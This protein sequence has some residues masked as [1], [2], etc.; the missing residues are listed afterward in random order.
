M[1]KKTI[2]ASVKMTDDTKAGAAGV[3]SSAEKVSAALTKM[4]R[5]V[6]KA[7]MLSIKERQSAERTL[8]EQKMTSLRREGEMG[9]QRAALDA[10]QLE[11]TIRLKRERQELLKIAHAEHASLQQKANAYRQINA[12]ER[13]AGRMIAFS[14]FPA[15]AGIS[16]G[17]M[18]S[19][20]RPSGGGFMPMFGAAMPAVGAAVIGNQVNQALEGMRQLTSV[21]SEFADA[22]KDLSSIG[23]NLKNMPAIRAGVLAASTTYG[24]S[25]TDVANLQFNVESSTAGMAPDA[26]ANI[27]R[28][29]LKMGRVAA[30]DLKHFGDAITTAMRQYGLTADAAA[31]F[32]F[33]AAERGKISLSELSQRLPTVLPVA[34]EFGLSPREAFS[35]VSVATRLGGDPET[36]MTELRNIIL[37]MPNAEKMLSEKQGKP[38]VM[39]SDFAGQIDSLKGLDRNQLT[40]AFGDRAVAMV[41]SLRANVGELRDEMK[42]EAKGVV[43]A[44]L[45]DRMKDAGFAATDL[46]K[47]LKQAKENVNVGSGQRD[48][49]VANRIESTRLGRADPVADEML[50]GFL[51]PAD[52]LAG[53]IRGADAKGAYMLAMEAAKAG[54]LD[55]FER[56]QANAI[57]WGG[58]GRWMG[59]DFTPAMVE[60]MVAEHAGLKHAAQTNRMGAAAMKEARDRTRSDTAAGALKT[61]A[62]IIGIRPMSKFEDEQVTKLQDLF[63]LATDQ[64]K[65]DDDGRMRGRHSVGRPE[66]VAP[67][68]AKAQAAQKEFGALVARGRGRGVLAL[69]DQAQYEQGVNRLGKFLSEFVKPDG[70]NNPWLRARM[71]DL[72]S[73]LGERVHEGI[74]SVIGK[75]NAGFLGGFGS[76]RGGGPQDPFKSEV[77]K[78]LEDRI[79]MRKQIPDYAGTELSRYLVGHGM[80]VEGGV[81]KKLDEMVENQKKAT[82]ALTELAANFARIGSF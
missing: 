37:R 78:E 54:D 15:G 21:A 34:K 50:P 29:S 41:L 12:L 19:S 75:G 71:D 14:A 4:D 1:A 69:E 9:S 31:D 28:S 60:R 45:A 63:A 25:P 17:G 51:K 5:E 20:V 49:D 26:A 13:S 80:K 33:M 52:L 66:E 22:L 73:A 44:R 39:P 27:T 3:A 43:D 77:F 8:M 42:I 38:F 7:A 40:D 47:S 46:A 11:M 64:P 36:T 70:K 68:F 81:E 30:G 16:R 57:K 65:F 76:K 23:S 53:R 67:A 72:P 55:A 62:P 58:E 32:I 74:A 59:S 18:G 56:H 2:E 10:R 35:A 61:L 24:R 6:T 48:I 82:Q 79:T